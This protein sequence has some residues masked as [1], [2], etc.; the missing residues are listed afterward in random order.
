M[1]KRKTILIVDDDTSNLLGLTGI[2]KQDYKIYAVKD[3][4]TAL[5]KAAE[6]LPDIILLDVLM[7]DMNGFEVLAALKKSNR[8]KDIPVIFITGMN[9]SEIERD[10]LAGG[11]VDYIRKPFDTFVVLHR[12]S[13]QFQILDLQQ[14]LKKAEAVVREPMPYGRVLIVDDTEANLYVAVRLMKRY[15]L[16]IDTA[17]SGREAIDK[18]TNGKVYDIIFMDHMM[19]EMDGIE[20]TKHLRE[21]GYTGTIAALTANAV[22]GQE[23]MYLE[24]GFDVFISKPIDTR[25]LDSILVQYIRDKQSPEVTKSACIQENG[26]DLPNDFEDDP[27]LLE[28]CIRDARK[29]VNI[30]DE[31]GKDPVWYENDE[32]LQRYVINIH[33]IKS[34]LASIGE[35]VLSETA[36]E[37]EAAGRENNRDR[38]RTGAP[39]FLE[40]LRAL[41][42]RFEQEYNAD[43]DDT[44][45]DVEELCDKLG[46]FIEMC[47]DFNRK[48]ALDILTGMDSFSGDVK[49]VINSLKELI[50]HSEFDKAADVAAELAEE[51][52]LKITKNTLFK[53]REIAGLD[54]ARGLTRYDDDEATYLKVLRSYAASTRS[55]LGEIENVSEDKLNDYKIRV[56]G[57]KGASYDIYAG[58][59]G[60]AAE[61]LEKAAKNSDYDH[62]T[63]ANPGFLKAS[64]AFISGIEELLHTIESENPKP[65]KDKPDAGSLSKLLAACDMYSMDEVDVAMAE[66]ERYKY[67]SDD[68]LADWL[69]YN[70]DMMRFPQIVEKLTGI[71]IQ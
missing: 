33:G 61:D 55:M 1:E 50:I 22:P 30:F 49:S 10:G 57:I 28:S 25:R 40:Q 16:Q 23:E 58:D 45:E 8:T 26:D 59:I 47:A 48:G 70:V 29:A 71:E 7:P 67:T 34:V 65:V 17:E 12:V 53:N 42:V 2:L 24:N 14:R 51:L 31:L 43:I 18:I 19:P 60:K 5:E 62:I 69:R 52:S 21:L 4:K 37:L 38:I 56:H 36:K 9:E 39:E 46:S 44:E 3:G 41:L 20:A 63:E 32:A 64:Y 15:K 6:S 11:A 27:F 13:L 54:I 68:G 66:I 35:T